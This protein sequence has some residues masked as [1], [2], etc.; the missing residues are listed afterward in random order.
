LSPPDDCVDVAGVTRGACEK[1]GSMG[2]A[3][4][5]GPGLFTRA[6]TPP[7]CFLARLLGRVLPVPL[8]APAAAAAGCGG[9]TMQNIPSNPSAVA[10]AVDRHP[11]PCLSSH[12]TPTGATGLPGSSWRHLPAHLCCWLLVMLRRCGLWCVEGCSCS[13]QGGGT[14]ASGRAVA[15]E[16][17]AI[18]QCVRLARLLPLPQRAA[19]LLSSRA[20]AP[21]SS[22]RTSGSAPWCS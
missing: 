22:D 6:I 3:C 15:G 2:Q 8:L 5:S 13:E 9:R 19:P 1:T 7:F 20:R 10:G 18:S 17:P 12:G 14:A 4:Q 16:E 11:R 21:P